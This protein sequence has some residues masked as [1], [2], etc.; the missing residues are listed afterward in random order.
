MTTMQGIALDTWAGL[1]D[2]LLRGEQVKCADRARASGRITAPGLE[3]KR[4]CLADRSRA[5]GPSGGSGGET[6]KCE[7]EGSLIQDTDIT[8]ILRDLGDTLRHIRVAQRVQMNDL[9]GMAN[10]SPSALSRI[11]RGVRADNGIRQL[12]AI[13][14]LLGVRLSAALRFSESWAMDGK[15]PWPWDGS[16][17][18]I[19][20][21]I[22]SPAVS[23]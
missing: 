9:A 7:P 3:R 16:N 20:D 21:A 13:S 23:S 8:A 2:Q 4:P 15:G 22:L 19:V 11:E 10:L 14:G 5:G 1:R 12:Y 6:V 18:P 17:S